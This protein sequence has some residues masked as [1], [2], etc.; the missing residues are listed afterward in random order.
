M[1]YT[2]L[3]LI[4]A[5]AIA[6]A[7]ITSTGYA[8]EPSDRLDI[9]AARVFQTAQDCRTVA[10]SDDGTRVANFGDKAVAIFVN[11]QKGPSSWIPLRAEAITRGVF[12]PDYELRTLWVERGNALRSVMIFRPPLYELNRSQ[13]KHKTVIGMSRDGKTLALRQDRKVVVRSLETDLGSRTLEMNE[14]DAPR[15]KTPYGIRVVAISDD[16]SRGVALAG[17]FSESDV[18]G[19]PDEASRVWAI[20]GD[21]L[22]LIIDESKTDSIDSTQRF[23][24]DQVAVAAGGEVA[25]VTGREIA[26]GR[27]RS[28]CRVISLAKPEESRLYLFDND[29]IRAMDLSR[30]GKYLASVW[31]KDGMVSSL[32]AYQEMHPGGERGLDTIKL[33][34]VDGWQTVAESTKP[35]KSIVDV[36][37]V[38][39]GRQLFVARQ[40]GEVLSWKLNLAGKK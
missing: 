20:R 40:N 1:A 14:A 10:V 21:E 30:D 35:M 4:S 7:G 16:G 36:V 34:A 22:K 9:A 6:M 15:A 26:K 2:A 33:I 8:D 38:D 12:S 17:M 25:V 39:D 28:C 29:S 32:R 23:H 31:R 5:G 18:L 37:M 3:R 24:W 13:Y 19:G 11:G 27:R